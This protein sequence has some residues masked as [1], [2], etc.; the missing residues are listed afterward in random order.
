MQ[1]T[2]EAKAEHSHLTA[3]QLQAAKER[4]LNEF[5]NLVRDNMECPECRKVCSE[6]LKG[7]GKKKPDEA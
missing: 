2:Q 5:H 3:K 7:T 6:A 1:Q 4:D